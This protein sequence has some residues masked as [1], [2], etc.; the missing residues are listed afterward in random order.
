MKTDHNIW[1]LTFWSFQSPVAD[2]TF[3]WIID[4]STLASTSGLRF[5][6]EAAKTS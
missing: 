6:K 3:G 1:E 4:H 5:K 2:E